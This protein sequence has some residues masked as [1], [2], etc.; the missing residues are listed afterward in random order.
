MN[1]RDVTTAK[2][3]EYFE[4]LNSTRDKPLAYSTLNSHANVIRQ[5]CKLA[6]E[7]RVITDIPIAP[8]I[9]KHKKEN[10]H[11]KILY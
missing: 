11:S 3:R 9:K 6:Y 10:L 7:D 8:E 2:I 4:R 1:I 5:I